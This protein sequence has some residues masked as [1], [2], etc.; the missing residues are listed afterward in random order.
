MSVKIG[1]IAETLPTYLADKD[2]SQVI[3]L[4]DKNTNKHCYP[5]VK[6]FLPSHILVKIKPGEAHKTLATCQEIW[7]TMTDANM[8]RHALMIDLGGGVIGDM[9]GFCAATYKRGIDFIQIPTTLLAQ[10]DASV[11]GKLG[12][13]F[14]GF[15][16]HI[17]V[18]Q[19]PQTVLIDSVF[20]KTLPFE[21]LRS[22]FAEITK[23]CLIQDAK[24]WEEIS[25]LDFDEQKFDDLIAHSIEIKK[26][27]VAADPTEKGLRK[28]LNFGHTLG[29]AVETYFLE[30]GPKHRLLH[31]EAI[32][33][34]MIC[35]AF[36]SLER[37]MIDQKLFE[38]IE[39]FIFSVYGKVKLKPD[40]IPAILKH[41]LQDKKNK[42]A[43]VRFSL[44]DGR[45]SCTFDIICNKAEMKSALLYYVG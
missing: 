15:K 3:V 44:L 8:D 43:K 4:V 6:D 5:L 20:L 38:E 33:V 16:N 27:V 32:A 9:G 26:K 41:T 29:H 17:G 42:G 2:Y 14:N 37:G 10:V 31:G 12:I 24:K 25:S 28:I 18:F 36:L 19:L 34:G 35:E 23:H 11:G 45:G 39:E 21:E 40:Y 1:P 13:D 22:G 30:K 7:Q